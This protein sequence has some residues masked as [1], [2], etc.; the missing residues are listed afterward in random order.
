[1]AENSRLKYHYFYVVIKQIYAYAL[2]ILTVVILSVN[3]IYVNNLPW[4]L[5]PDLSSVTTMHNL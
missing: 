2:F 5:A 1:M 3:G 4:I